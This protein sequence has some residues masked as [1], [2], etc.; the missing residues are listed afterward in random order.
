MLVRRMCLV[1]CSGNGTPQNETNGLISSGVFFDGLMT[2]PRMD[3]SHLSTASLSSFIASTST[4]FY[5]QCEAYYWTRPTPW[6]DCSHVRPDSVRMINVFDGHT[7]ALHLCTADLLTFTPS[8]KRPLRLQGVASIASGSV[9]VVITATPYP[10]LPND[11]VSGACPRRSVHK[12]DA[13]AQLAQP[14]A[15][16]QSITA[17]LFPARKIPDSTQESHGAHMAFKRHISAI[18]R[19]R[20]A[21]ALAASASMG[22]IFYGWDIGVIGGVI[23][24]PSFR[25]YFGL[26]KMSS[27]AQADLSGNIVAV[28]QGG[29]FFGA[30]FTGYLSGR[31]GRKPTLIAS[32]VI[33]LIGSLIQCLVGIGT[34]Q[35]VALRLFYFSRFLAGLGVGM[36]SALV[37]SYV[38]EC[39]PKSIRGRCTGMVQL[40]NNV[41]IMLSCESAT[42]CFWQYVNSHAQFGLITVRAQT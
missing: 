16:T 1:L 40:A 9:L 14:A 32:G 29:A 20:H 39:V 13:I 17:S 41:G 10:A 4:Y 3:P 42:L 15:R 11:Q 24:L 27:S 7:G 8:R 18:A 5:P 25:A 35:T 30:L 12:A 26:A 2:A 21:Y 28:L 38:S 34:S 23:T 22:S 31:F 36:V 6:R 37:P 19:Y 33:Y